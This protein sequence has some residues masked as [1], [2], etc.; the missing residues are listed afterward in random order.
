MK[1]G[2]VT[3]SQLAEKWLLHSKKVLQDPFSNEACVKA[4]REAEQFL[5]AGHEMDHVCELLHGYR[6]LR[7][8][9]SIL[10]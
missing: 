8:A 9:C 5:W 4:L 1:G 2:R 3:L 10:L 7:L 6:F